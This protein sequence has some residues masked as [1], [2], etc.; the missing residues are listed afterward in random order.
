LAVKTA[1]AT[2]KIAALTVDRRTKTIDGDE[3]M[4]SVHKLTNSK[5]AQLASASLKTTKRH[6]IF[7]ITL[8]NNFPKLTI[9]KLLF[10]QI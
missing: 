7:N 5:D 2:P 6:L 3:N 8:T 1:L 9:K 10:E 4:E